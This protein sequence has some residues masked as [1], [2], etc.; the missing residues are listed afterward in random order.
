MV[1]ETY[2]VTRLL[3]RGGMGAVWEARHQRLP[4]KRVAIKV[5]HPD[6]ARDAEALA[7]FRREA[8]IA[9]RLGHP[10]II[11]VHDFNQLADG[12]PY[13]VLEFLQGE[14]LDARMAR[15]PLSLDE[16]MTIARQI[17]YGLRA[18]HEQ[19]I[20]HRDLKPQNVFLVERTGDES[21]KSIAKVL[22]FGISKI[23]GSQTVKTQDATILGTPQYMAPEQAVGN[24][25]AVDART[26]VF[27]LGAILYEALC[28]RPAFEGQT[29]PEV[30]F[31]V[32]YEEP[33]PLSQRLPSC[34]P[35]INAAIMRALA[36]K[37]DERFPD[38]NSF[39]ESL[40]GRPMSAMAMPVAVPGGRQSAEAHAETV[41]SRQLALMKLGGT[42]PT[43]LAQ[44]SK[45]F[46]MT[47]PD[48]APPRR[49]AGFWLAGLGLM[50]GGAAVALFLVMTRPDEQSV[51]PPSS[52]PVAQTTATPQT[53]T[54]SPVAQ[55]TALPPVDAPDAAP[56]DPDAG[57]ATAVEP[58]DAAVATADAGHAAVDP[59]PVATP[60]A[61]AK[62]PE[63]T[64]AAREALQRGEA[65]LKAG[66]GSTAIDQGK[67]AVRA[68]ASEQ[69]YLLIGK[70]FCVQKDLGRAKIEWRKLST[71]GKRQ[72]KEYCQRFG[73]SL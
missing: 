55:T 18:A 61:G 36:K 68:G 43:M 42:A 66:D 28:G 35:H 12:A 39:I 52:D 54:T 24:H 44:D 48:Q 19:N 10:N 40:S 65:A 15:G 4:G 2:E 7:R 62:E 37:Q 5:L 31:K 27:A 46:D 21:G 45:Q 70:S 56:A 63:L 73:V 17:G 25:A 71:S 41:D 53:T 57:A 11:E 3:G 22:D 23:R 34:P 72:L 13:L 59:T 60:D 58:E 16:L 20:F 38:M 47:V 14:S 49:R 9:S 8:E 69:G 67:R 50:V 32:V 30:V 6:I 33:V 1:A 29:I 26:D 64:P 51:T